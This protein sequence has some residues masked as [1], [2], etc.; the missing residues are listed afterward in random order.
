MNFWGGGGEGSKRASDRDDDRDRQMRD[1][2]KLEAAQS[3]QKAE[4][5][6]APQL[7][8]ESVPESI[9]MTGHGECYHLSLSCWRYDNENSTLADR[10]RSAKKKC[11]HNKSFENHL[12]NDQ[13]LNGSVLQ[14]EIK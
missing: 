3:C 4:I 8:R 12:S 10:A 2:T 14:Q 7:P 6:T 5:Q 9:F 1:D 13:L 11:L